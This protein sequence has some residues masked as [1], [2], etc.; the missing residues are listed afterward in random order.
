M[1]LYRTPEEVEALY[2]EAWPADLIPTKHRD[3]A[4][5]ADFGTRG[6]PRAPYA[7]GDGLEDRILLA[8]GDGGSGRTGTGDLKTYTKP[9]EVAHTRSLNP[10]VDC[11]G[12]RRHSLFCNERGVILACGDGTRG[13]LGSKRLPPPPESASV[14]REKRRKALRKLRDTD[15]DSSDLT[16][17]PDEAPLYTFPETP[18]QIARRQKKEIRRKVRE[19]RAK[20]RGLMTTKAKPMGMSSKKD[21]ST[22]LATWLTAGERCLR[23][24]SPTFPSGSINAAFQDVHA[25]QVS[26]CAT[27][28]FARETNSAEAL[29]TRVG[30]HRMTQLVKRREAEN[31]YDATTARLR[32]A[33]VEEASSCVRGA[34]GRILC[35]GTGRYGELGLGRLR[36]QRANPTIVALG[37]RVQAIACGKAHILALCGQE[38]NAPPA[39]YAW[40][41]GRDGRL[42]LG[43]YADR[44]EP[45]RVVFFDQE[46][47]TPKIIA[48]GDAHSLV[49]VDAVNE[50][51][52]YTWGR[53]AHGRLG[54]LRTLN[55]KTPQRVTAWPS[56]FEG[57]RVIDAALGG[58]HSLVLAERACSRSGVN[59]WGRLRRV[60][61]WG[62]GGNGQL[63]DEA[64]MDRAVPTWVKLPP[65]EVITHVAC[66]KAHS[67]CITAH[68]DLYAW[69]KGEKGELGQ[70]DFRVRCGPEKVPGKNQYLKVAAG[71]A[72][73]LAIALKH[74]AIGKTLRERR[75]IDAVNAHVGLARQA[76]C[77]AQLGYTCVRSATTSKLF[78]APGSPKAM[79]KP[80]RPVYCKT[81][82]CLAL[83][84]WCAR[85][86]HAGH[87]LIDVDE[88]VARTLP[89]RS[90]GSSMDAEPPSSSLYPQLCECGFRQSCKRLQVSL[91]SAEEDFEKETLVLQRF[92]R[93]I[94]AR[95]KV[96]AFKASVAFCRRY[97]AQ[98]AWG[99]PNLRGAVWRRASNY[100]ATKCSQMEKPRMREADVEAHA[101][102]KYL[103]CQIILQACENQVHALRAISAA[104]GAPDPGRTPW[105]EPE[106]TPAP[107]PEEEARATSCFDLQN[108]DA[109]GL[110]E[111]HRKGKPCSKCRMAMKKEAASGPAD[112]KWIL[113]N[114]QAPAPAPAAEPTPEPV[115][116]VEPVE[117]ESDLRH[118]SRRALR[119]WHRRHWRLERKSLEETALIAEEH[120]LPHGGDFR[121]ELGLVPDPDVNLFVL[122]AR[123]DALADAED[124][125]AASFLRRRASISAPEALY[126]RARFT[127]RDQ[128]RRLQ[129][130]RSPSLDLEHCR[131]DK[132]FVYVPEEEETPAK[133]KKKRRRLVVEE[134]DAERP[135]L[136]PLL[137]LFVH[138]R[139]LRSSIEAAQD[140]YDGGQLREAREGVFKALSEARKWLLSD[141]VT[142]F[143]EERLYWQEPTQVQ[144]ALASS[145]VLQKLYHAPECPKPPRHIRD[146][147]T[148]DQ[149][150]LD[151]RDYLK[152][153]REVDFAKFNAPPKEPLAPGELTPPPTPRLEAPMY[154]LTRSLSLAAPERAAATVDLWR[155]HV[156]YFQDYAANPRKYR[157]MHGRPQFA[158]L[159]VQTY[160]VLNR[161]PEMEKSIKGFE[162]E[163]DALDPDVAAYEEPERFTD[164]QWVQEKEFIEQCALQANRKN[165][166][167][168]E[169]EA[170]EETADEET[171]DEVETKETVE[172]RVARKEAKRDARREEKRAEKDARRVEK[173]RAKEAERQELRRDR[174][175]KARGEALKK[176]TPKKKKKR[177]TLDDDAMRSPPDG[178]A[179]PLTPSPSRRGTPQFG[180][181]PGTSGTPRAGTPGR[182]RPRTPATPRWQEHQDDSGRTYY[183]NAA[184]GETSWS[185]PAVGF[186]L[187]A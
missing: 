14:K 99:G 101:V 147:L 12:G 130:R 157:D 71:D 163:R 7:D 1:A 63:G 146:L 45:E 123:H 50:G 83:C 81:C 3:L 154:R 46:R 96:T 177:V 33:L 59:P 156:S 166:I 11:A 64:L 90:N 89:P 54:L 88:D 86:C 162:I 91:E 95:R 36:L 148:R 19:K 137:P 143:E 23:Y 126:S 31:G 173:A 149:D 61:A 150:V 129:S 34:R 102:R 115:E 182:G 138:E 78:P 111:D 120:Q 107:T 75:P 62:Y 178:P 105:V 186:I 124:A 155:R 144:R 187:D 160:F 121:I 135:T 125:E 60:Y 26:C 87:E 53:G 77:V 85:I 16:S 119:Q 32:A 145:S 20:A 6:Y 185:K 94:T 9:H 139:P 136:H 13:Q 24:P 153:Q 114:E 110:V 44:N 183:F 92:A 171:D 5:N 164:E 72:H 104:T 179:S 39:L 52:V 57:M 113:L 167:E 73:T 98:T 151:R 67:L 70:G 117:P 51:G 169:S 42:G 25:T 184:T 174:E 74:K 176:K 131:E 97:A 181:R 18:K 109:W 27:A 168:S 15:S 69:G 106:P 133:N 82:D 132:S 55:K 134:E 141:A 30:L 2:R 56:N 180:S 128:T 80:T 165:W 116:P 66:G 58:A 152:R 10:F 93:W 47:L 122:R 100:V 175:A 159:D 172:E 48:T 76:C 43:D 22:S 4:R 103:K 38:T 79:E 17:D 35:W 108:T 65:S 118:R 68:G 158:N 49:V 140:A 28:S 37:R 29:Q 142:A 8:W 161:P 170:D 40:G 84:P 112:C 127:R 21:G 41:R